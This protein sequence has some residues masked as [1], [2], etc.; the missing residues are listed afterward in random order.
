MNGDTKLSAPATSYVATVAQKG[1]NMKSLD[2]SHYFLHV[3]H[4]T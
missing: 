4:P 2:F 1:Q 3:S